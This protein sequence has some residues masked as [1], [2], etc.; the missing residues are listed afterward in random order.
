MDISSAAESYVPAQI[1][2]QRI[3]SANKEQDAIQA[4][5]QMGEQIEPTHKYIN[6]DQ[7][8]NFKPKNAYEALLEEERAIVTNEHNYSQPPT[9]HLSEQTDSASETQ[10]QQNRQISTL[11]ESIALDHGYVV[12]YYTPEIWEELEKVKP[13]SVRK[14]KEYKKRQ[15]KLKD[16]TNL[17][18]ASRELKNLLQPVKPE[19]LKEYEPP[20]PLYTSRSL[21]EEATNMYSILFSG[22]IIYVHCFGLISNCEIPYISTLSSCL[23]T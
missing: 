10:E 6:K 14:R 1:D 22:K 5:L 15:P 23:D 19:E 17:R 3:S 7:L 8:L 18:G 4:L 2:A 11:P 13:K 16:V 21:Q 12:R 20:K 9:T